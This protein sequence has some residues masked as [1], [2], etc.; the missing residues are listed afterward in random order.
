MGCN[1][2]RSP[3]YQK[4]H[5]WRNQVEKPSKPRKGIQSAFFRY[6]IIRLWLNAII[7]L[8]FLETFVLTCCGPHNSKRIKSYGCPSKWDPNGG[9]STVQGATFLQNAETVPYEF[10]SELYWI[11]SGFYRGAPHSTSGK[12]DA[13]N[14]GARFTKSIPRWRNRVEKTSKPRKGIQS[15]FFRYEIIRLRLDVMIAVYLWETFVLAD[16]GPRNS[17]R[18][19]SYGCPSKWDPNGG[20][21]TVQGAT[22][23]QNAETAPYEFLSELY[24]IENEFYH[25]APH[26]TTG[27]WDPSNRGAHLQKASSVKKSSRK[28]FEASKRHSKC[29][30]WLCNHSVM[31]RCRNSC[32][33]LRYLRFDRLWPP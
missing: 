27:K 1:Q 17:K 22:F 5:R 16:C 4:H 10:L 20:T 7:V 3:F 15:V 30:F 26:S 29:V 8:Y 32:V 33:S 18:V 2:P 25:G 28:N 11:E 19:K 24:G 13:I 31:A 21:S 6:E 23:L 9:T 12:W 14:R